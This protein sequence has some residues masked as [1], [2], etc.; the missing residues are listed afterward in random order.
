MNEMMCKALCGNTD[1]TKDW[2]VGYASRCEKQ[3]TIVDEDGVGV[4]VDGNTVC[5]CT[6][7][8]D[9]NGKMIWENDILRG[10]GNPNDLAKAVFGEFDVIEVESLERIDKVVGW[11]TEVIPTD[12]ISRAEPFCLSMPLTD[13]YIKLSEW[14]VIGNCF[15]NPELLERSIV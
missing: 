15:S 10:H 11:H 3:P 2:I 1:G 14:E 6:N 8:T 12:A 7:M 5:R 9:K 4:F 13:F